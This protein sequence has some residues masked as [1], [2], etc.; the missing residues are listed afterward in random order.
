MNKHLGGGEGEGLRV[1]KDVFS[2]ES[3]GL[4]DLLI[5]NS[6]DRDITRGGPEDEGG[7]GG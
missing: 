1:G 5:V 6:G 3:R 2:W 7:G 4:A